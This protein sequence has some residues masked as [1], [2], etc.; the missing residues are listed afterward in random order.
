MTMLDEIFIDNG[1]RR[2]GGYIVGIWSN[3]AHVDGSISYTR[4][5]L[6]QSALSAKDAEIAELRRVLGV[7]KVVA[8]SAIPYFEEAQKK[9][10]YEVKPL[11]DARNL[12]TEIEKAGV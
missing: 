5:D 1:G 10:S 7:A 4:T 3:E 6:H 2:T 11:T 12:I 9:A 8:K